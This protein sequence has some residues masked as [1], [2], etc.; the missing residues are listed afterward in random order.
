[1]NDLKVSEKLF[2]FIPVYGIHEFEIESISDI[3]DNIK[4]IVI[5]GINNYTNSKVVLLCLFDNISITFIKFLSESAENSSHW[6]R[7]GEFKIY[8]NP[9]KAY[10]AACARDLIIRKKNLKEF[11]LENQIKIAKM[12]S[13]ISNYESN[14]KNLQFLLNYSKQYGFRDSSFNVHKYI[15]QYLQQETQPC[16]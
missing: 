2:A 1:M 16:K 5:T 13:D 8:N 14:Y 10:S 15:D 6:Y 11:K 9:F 7:L 12:D 4:H 3:S